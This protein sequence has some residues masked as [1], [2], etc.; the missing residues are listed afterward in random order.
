MTYKDVETTKKEWA[1]LLLPIAL[2]GGFLV[3]GLFYIIES[4]QE[5]YEFFSSRDITD[6]NRIVDNP[7]NWHPI[8]GTLEEKFEYCTD[9]FKPGGMNDS[10]IRSVE[11]F[12][13]FSIIVPIAIALSIIVMF[14]TPIKDDKNGKEKEN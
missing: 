6:C 5:M 11:T 8:D 13:V 4:S 2:S 12:W 10:A 1:K 7:E 9:W 14:R 3:F